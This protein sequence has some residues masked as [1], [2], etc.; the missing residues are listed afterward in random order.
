MDTIKERLTKLRLEADAA[1]EKAEKAER[2]KKDLEQQ[3][4][5]K[6]Q[7]IKSLTHRL[8]TAE[9]SLDTS[10]THLNEAKRFREDHE[11][12]K[13]TN[14]G[15]LRKIQLLEDELDSAEKNLKETVERLRQM[16]VK[17]EHFERQVH[18]MEKDKENLEK[19]NQELAEKWQKSQN[20]LDA[21]VREME[22][23]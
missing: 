17:A 18:S 21:L 16:D 15:L 9:Q 22:S 12:S 19:K 3:V 23:L 10:E 11:T 8:A 13:A 20:D 2:E 4:L 14:D 6:D 7:E 1:L 5:V